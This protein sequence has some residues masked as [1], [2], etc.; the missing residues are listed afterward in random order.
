MDVDD[1]E[2]ALYKG[3][4]LL[5]IG[6]L[7]EIAEAENVQIKTIQFYMTPTYKKRIEKRKNARNYRE[8]VCL[9]E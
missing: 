1:K 5:R 7:E 6:T 2:Y 8:V 3:E 4:E 9:G